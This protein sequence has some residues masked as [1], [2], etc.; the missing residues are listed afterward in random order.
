MAFFTLPHFPVVSYGLESLRKKPS[1]Q[2]SSALCEHADDT[3]LVAT[4]KWPTILVIYLE[5][6]LG[7]LEIWLRDWRIAIN[8]SKSAVMLFMSRHIPNLDRS[9]FL[10]MR[11]SRLKKIK[12]LGSP[13]IKDLPGLVT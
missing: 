9:G 11:F 7:E 1:L 13:L 4:S 3:V 10:E 12:Y 2:Y 8:V 6:Y 5:T